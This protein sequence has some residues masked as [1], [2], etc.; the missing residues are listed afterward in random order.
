LVEP[1]VQVGFLDTITEKWA[2]LTRDE[3]TK[4][5]L[6]Q[7]PTLDKRSFRLL[8]PPEE[9]PRM[10]ALLEEHDVVLGKLDDLATPSEFRTGGEVSVEVTFTINKGI[11]RCMAKYAF[12]FLALTCGTGFVLSDDFD[13]I[14]QFVRYG[15][16]TDYPLVVEALEPILR[17]DT[18]HQRQTAG[19]LLTVNWT[20]SQQDLV[21]QVS[22]FNAVTYRV[23]LARGF[24]GLWRP[25]TAGL[26]FNL[27]SKTIQPLS[28]ISPLLLP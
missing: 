2:Y 10:L 16:E 12:N 6:H 26:H 9:Q 20:A 8:A 22:L 23:S 15:L 11:R 17:D 28:A 3:V 24:T 5:V 7:R 14:R 25:V 4:G 18:A 21:G 13:P 1:L 27:H 19:H